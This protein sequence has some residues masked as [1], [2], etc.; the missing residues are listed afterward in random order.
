[1]GAIA[2]RTAL[3]RRKAV[4]YTNKR[5]GLMTEIMNSI[6]LIKMYGWEESFLKKV[7]GVFLRMS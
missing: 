5:V 7:K 1:M 3:I 4:R 2:R 6:R